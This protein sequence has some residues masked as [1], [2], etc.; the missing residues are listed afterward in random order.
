MDVGGSEFR[1]HKGR[2]MAQ[3]GRADEAKA[4]FDGLAAD[5][6]AQQAQGGEVDFFMK[7]GER[8]AQGQRLARAHYLA[9]LGALGHDDLTA[10]RDQFEKALQANPNHLW[11][12]VYLE[13]LSRK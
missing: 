3:L 10:A 9:G 7:F 12:R 11:A 1:Y 2:A 6:A 5:G 13:E 8:Q 4:L